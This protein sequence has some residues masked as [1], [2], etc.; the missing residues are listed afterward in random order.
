FITG[1]LPWFDMPA[2]G[3]ASQLGGLLVFV[4]SS[5]AFLLAAHTLDERW[6][7]RLV[8]LFIASGAIIV[9]GRFVPPLSGVIN[10]FSTSGAQGSVFWIWLVAL[11]AGLAMFHTSLSPRMR[12]A[13][14]AVAGLTLLF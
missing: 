13:L 7:A 9:I 10:R 5:A 6:L 2:A 3:A 4:I 1:Q 14:A 12:L 8:Y 11:P